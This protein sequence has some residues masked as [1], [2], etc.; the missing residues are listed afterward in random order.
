MAELEELE[1]EFVE[2][3]QQQVGLSPEQAHQVAG[4]ALQF[5]GDHKDDLLKIAAAQGGGGILGGILGR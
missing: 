3:M 2:T 4:V 1:S 5:A